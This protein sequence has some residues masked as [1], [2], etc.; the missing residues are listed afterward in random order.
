MTNASSSTVSVTGQLMKPGSTFRGLAYSIIINAVFPYI[1]YT[2]LKNYTSVSEL[3]ALLISGVPPI[4]DTIVGVIR[5]GRVDLIA[6]IA[7]ASIVI[8]I[9][10]FLVGGSPRVY[11]IRESFFTAAIGLSYLVSML[12]PKPLGFYFARAFVTGNVPEKV[13]WFNSLWQYPH[14]RRSM[15]VTTVVWGIGFLLEVVIRTYLVVTLT[16]PQFLLI[17]P[18]VLYGF[19]GGITLWTIWYSRNGRKRAAALRA[20]RETPE[21]TAIEETTE[22]TPA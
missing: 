13:E 3:V 15:R 4:I 20:Q 10:L 21:T 2:L 11:L 12:F 7:L 19:I 17:S 22:E 6:G 14:F 16:I 5:K 9:V 1:I 8:G 18:F